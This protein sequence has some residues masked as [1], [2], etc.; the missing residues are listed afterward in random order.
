MTQGPH[1]VPRDVPCA[2][3]ES[4]GGSVGLKLPVSA[5]RASAKALGAQPNF[6]LRT[7]I[8]ADGAGGVPGGRL[9]LAEGTREEQRL[10]IKACTRTSP[11]R[12]RGER[13]KK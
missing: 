4:A 11:T 8:V 7:D 3:T 12:L 13:G 2:G 6:N 5:Y 1:R 10:Q 9:H